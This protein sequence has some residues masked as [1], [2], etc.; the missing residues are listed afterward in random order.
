MRAFRHRIRAFRRH[1]RPGRGLGYGNA[2][3]L[4]I[5]RLA[6]IRRRARNYKNSGNEAKKYLKT[7]DITFLMLQIARP[8]HANRHKSELERSEIG[9]FFAKRSEAGKAGL[10]ERQLRDQAV[11]RRRMRPTLRLLEDELRD[12]II[13]EAREVV[14]ELGFE[15][16]NVPVLD[17]LAEHGAKVDKDDCNAR[18]T[19][20]PH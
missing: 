17:L 5:A 1:T 9:A 16:H 8:L 6:A 7:K 4:E 12:R 3:G 13:S 2:A 15:I 14:C 18:L 11:L 19:P 10:G 20:R